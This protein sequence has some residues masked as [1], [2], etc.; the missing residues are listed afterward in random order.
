MWCE[1]GAAPV[2]CVDAPGNHRSI[3]ACS[4]RPHMAVFSLSLAFLL[5]KC[6]ILPEDPIHME[7]FTFVFL[8]RISARQWE[9]CARYTKEFGDLRNLHNNWE[10]GSK[11]RWLL[12]AACRGCKWIYSPLCAAWLKFRLR[13]SKSSTPNY[14][15]PCQLPDTTL[16][17]WASSLARATIMFSRSQAIVLA[18]HI[19]LC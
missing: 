11:A 1:V 10:E 5:M 12:C 7:Y 6:T 18:N 19:H 13:L 4:H 17:M 15:K 2:S 9:S 14:K 8:K 16:I 3:T